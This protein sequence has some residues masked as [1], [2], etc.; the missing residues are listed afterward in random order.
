MTAQSPQ[1]T[2]SA[3][4]SVL[5]NQATHPASIAVCVYTEERLPTLRCAIAA[6]QSQMG[7]EDEL[8][9]VVD[10]NDQLLERCRAELRDCR[11]IPNCHRRGLSGS[12]NTA[13]DDANGSIV[14]FIDDDAVPRSG[15]LEGLRAPYADAR[16]YG[17]GGLTMP[18]W[19]GVKPRWFP[20][21]FLWVVG[22]S[23]LGL[24]PD[25]HHIRNLTG[26]NMSFRRDIC[27]DLGGF[28]ESMGRVGERLRGCEET[29][30]S[31][32]LSQANPSAV[33]LYDP[34]AQVDHF[35]A[36]ERSSIAYFARRCWGEGIS[37]AEVSRRVGRSSALSSERHYASRVLTRGLWHGARDTA[38]GDLWGAARSIVILLGLAV[39]SA[40]YCAGSVSLAIRQP[41]S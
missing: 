15:W 24:P 30:F 26:A 40:G 1:M 7:S 8:V 16:V 29:E 4:S 13:I 34:A 31:I 19:L 41:S 36:L 11:V 39:T 38:R 14:I 22:C 18:R 17:V 5:S 21:E 12:R 35:L 27:Q 25:R 33:L 3:D 28:A 2:T 6:V 9:V 10:H 32:R 20:E 37:K 23:H